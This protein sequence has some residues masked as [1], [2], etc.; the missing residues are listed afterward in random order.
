LGAGAITTLTLQNRL[1]IVILPL[2]ASSSALM[3]LPL[4]II[5]GIK[6]LWCRLTNQGI[7]ACDDFGTN[8]GGTSQGDETR[9]R[10]DV[11]SLCAKLT[12]KA[13]D[14][15]YWSRSSEQA[16]FVFRG[17][18]MHPF[19]VQAAT[20]KDNES[21]WKG[22]LSVNP[23]S[24]INVHEHGYSLD[25]GPEYDTWKQTW[26]ADE[27]TSFSGTTHSDTFFETNRF[28]CQ[29]FEILYHALECDQNDDPKDNCAAAGATDDD[30]TILPNNSQFLDIS[31]KF[32]HF[33]QHIQKY[34]THWHNTK[35]LAFTTTTRT[36]I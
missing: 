12:D 36:Q 16:K 17:M 3:F 9:R 30:K 34:C 15:N 11:P 28:G 22:A 24:I 18:M 31:T 21:L 32:S 25:T 6:K 4:F 5:K 20:G 2:L 29:N 10:W 33:N 19:W 26:S 23:T 7:T 13:C 14:A 35:K 8:Q 27:V 1:Y